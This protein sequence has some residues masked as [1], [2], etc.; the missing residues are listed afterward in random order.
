MCLWHDYLIYCC[1]V[2][3][4]YKILGTTTINFTYFLQ[5]NIGLKSTRKEDQSKTPP[6]Q[7]V[8]RCNIKHHRQVR[9]E[10]LKLHNFGNR[11]FVVIK[12]VS[13]GLVTVRRMDSCNM[14]WW[15]INSSQVPSL[16]KRENWDYLLA[17]MPRLWWTEWTK[18]IIM[19]VQSS[20]V[21]RN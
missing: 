9:Q 18:L 20:C 2:V 17:V 1:W 14:N 3:N 13:V 19:H 5:N 8:C 4:F 11:E 15:W 6:S 7:A 10:I 12:C 21:L 16:T